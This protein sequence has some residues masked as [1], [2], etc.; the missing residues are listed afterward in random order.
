MKFK[1]LLL[2]LGVM[3][4]RA[5]K[6]KP[7]FKKVLEGKDMTFELSSVEGVCRSYTVKEDKVTSASGKIVEDPEF[8][9]RFETSTLGWDAL[10][11]PE[12]QA[13]FMRGIQDKTIRIEGNPMEVMWF[14]KAVEKALPSMLQ[15]KKK[16]KAVA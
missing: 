4:K 9:I 12:G 10:T 8:A 5:S 14:Q 7:E 6:N 11:K 13:I 2:A 16:K 15:P 3:M 1:L